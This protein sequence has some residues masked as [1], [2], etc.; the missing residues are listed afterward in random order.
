MV[1]DL[2]AEEGQRLPH[3][4]GHG[5]VGHGGGG[6]AARVVVDQHQRGG[7][8][9]EGAAGDFAGIDRRVVHGAAGLGF[10]GEQAAVGIEEQD[11]ELFDFL[12]GERGGE[13]GEEGVRVVEGR[14]GF[15][16]GAGE[17]ERGFVQELGAGD[18]VDAEA[19]H[20]EELRG[21]RGEKVGEA[22]EADERG[23]CE[24][25]RVGGA[26]DEAKQFGGE[27]QIVGR[28]GASARQREA[29]GGF[30]EAG[31]G[32]RRR[33]VY[34]VASGKQFL[35]FWFM[36]PFW[37]RQAVAETPAG[38]V[39]ASTGPHGHRARMRQRLLDRGAGALADYE[40]LEMLLFWAIERRDT[41]PQA[42]AAINAFG[43]FAG[44]VGAPPG[45]LAALAGMSGEV[46]RV[47]ALVRA[48]SAKLGGAEA[49]ARPVL[50][51]LLTLGA[52]LAAAPGRDGLRVLFLDTRN[53]LVADE[54]AEP[55]A[56][57]RRALALQVASV[58]LV[59]GEASLAALAR[60]RGEA[61]KLSLAVHDWV[62][63][64]EA[65]FLSLSSER[66]F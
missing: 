65:G 1:R 49:Q 50:G 7:A 37:R 25:G 62:V 21:R 26:G 29:E 45:E 19:G 18:A 11:A 46:G 12:A 38:P 64:E 54:M 6:I 9:F 51:D 5:H 43:S 10:V 40:V 44:V 48:A 58:I 13:V 53:R 24:R 63:S 61:A 17:A 8:E 15:Q 23:L 31:R 36:T 35:Y 41:K 39:F 66:L 34:T 22:A 3:L 42:K 33:H 30:G 2:D 20:G 47:L 52:Y 27:G 57:L 60:V 14:R 4:L 16:R 59:G 56:V 32:V 28:G 55:G